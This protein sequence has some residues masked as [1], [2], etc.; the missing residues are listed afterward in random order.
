MFHRVRYS[1]NW[2]RP[3]TY[4][5]IVRNGIFLS[6]RN[7]IFRS[8]LLLKI[9]NTTHSTLFQNTTHYFRIEKYIPPKWVKTGWSFGDRSFERCLEKIYRPINSKQSMPSL[10]KNG[11]SYYDTN[12]ELRARSRFFNELDTMPRSTLIEEI[13]LH[14]NQKKNLIKRI[15]ELEK[16]IL[17]EEKNSK[18]KVSSNPEVDRNKQIMSKQFDEA[19]DI[20]SPSNKLNK[21][22]SRTVSKQLLFSDE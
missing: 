6:Y 1:A 14:I 8:I 3:W 21:T 5:S 22:Y 10:F 16:I 12:R 13:K 15:E 18:E 9:L 17:S 11:T 20:A 2:R 4:F 7:H 19:F